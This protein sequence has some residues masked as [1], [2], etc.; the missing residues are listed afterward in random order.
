MRS[1]IRE[2]MYGFVQMSKR[3]CGLFAAVFLNKPQSSTAG[4]CYNSSEHTQRPSS[5]R[6]RELYEALLEVNSA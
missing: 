1:R 4:K 3:T 5:D 2:N 6:E